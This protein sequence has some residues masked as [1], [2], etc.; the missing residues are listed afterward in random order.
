[1][2]T[3]DLRG[4]TYLSPEAV[5]AVEDGGRPG[6]RRPTSELRLVRIPPIVRRALEQAGLADR[7]ASRCRRRE[8]LTPI[9]GTREES[10]RVANVF[11]SLAQLEEATS[12]AEAA[13]GLAAMLAEVIAP[14]ADAQRHDRPA[15]QPALIDSNGA[16]AQRLDGLQ[17]QAGEGPVPVGLGHPRAGAHRRPPDR[18]ALA[19]R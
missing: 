19:A 17:M 18:P 1:M 8:A 14:A 6:R 9:T 11:Q 5:R 7:R 4:V 12:E 16:F 13:A 2:H 3:V 10:L 15:G